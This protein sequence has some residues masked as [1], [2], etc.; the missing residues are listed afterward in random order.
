MIGGAAYPVPF[1]KSPPPVLVNHLIAGGGNDL[2]L[3]TEARDVIELGEG[4]DTAYA[5]GG[6]DRLDG[7]LGKD[8]LDGDEG[9]DLVIGDGG[10]DRLYGGSGED[11]LFAARKVLV[12]KPRP[13]TSGPYD[14]DDQVGCGPDR[15]WAAANPWDTRRG[16]GKV[17]LQP[18]P[19]HRR[20]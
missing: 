4:L 16:C 17:L 5:G 1:M 9:N 11:R 2:A 19:R 6:N 18:R 20:R 7:G 3:G 10:S 13:L 12:E 14:G 8:L 15:D